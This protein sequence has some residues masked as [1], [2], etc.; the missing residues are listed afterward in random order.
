[1]DTDKILAKVRS[2]SRVTSK[3]QVTIPKAV[4]DAYG[5]EPGSEIEFEPAGES[6]RVHVEGRT[7]HAGAEDDAEWR[8]KLF[9]EATRRQAV[10]NRAVVACEEDDRGWR[11][12]DLY[13]RG[14][15]D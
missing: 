1:M 14:V 5:I 15:S 2:M 3:L 6:I 7:G 11:R 4:A 8:L 9:D 13:G 10:R 12:E